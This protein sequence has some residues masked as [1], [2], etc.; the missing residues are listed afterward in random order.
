EPTSGLDPNQR[1]RIK[2]LVRDLGEDR[3]VLFSSH[4]LAEVEDVSSRVIIIDRGK[5][6]AD[7]DPRQLLAH[8]EGRRLVVCAA[9]SPDALRACL[10][11]VAGSC[12]V[13][14]PVRDGAFTTLC[15]DLEAGADPR[16]SAFE[17]L[18]GA[19]LRI[20]ELKLELPTLEEFFAR[21]TGRAG[22]AAVQEVAS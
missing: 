3:T 15:Y 5:I 2:T 1:R 18:Q 11:E 6:K 14:E 8:S 13:R 16:D 19:G 21:V 7:G 12:G 17:R 20:R 9:A 22:D 4:I 10:G